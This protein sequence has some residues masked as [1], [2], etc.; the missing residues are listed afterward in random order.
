MSDQEQNCSC[1]DYEDLRHGKICT[2]GALLVEIA[3]TRLS[4][5]GLDIPQGNLESEPELTLD[6]LGFGVSR[7]VLLQTQKLAWVEP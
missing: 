2:V 4:E 3:S 1:P 7:S 5:A 6:Q